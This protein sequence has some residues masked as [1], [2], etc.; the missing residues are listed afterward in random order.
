MAAPMSNGVSHSI[1]PSAPHDGGCGTCTPI[2]TVNNSTGAITYGIEY[3]TT[4]HF[5]KFILPARCGFIPAT[6]TESSAPR[7]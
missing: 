6:P 1:K 7:S 3:Y 4:G 5:S 2:V